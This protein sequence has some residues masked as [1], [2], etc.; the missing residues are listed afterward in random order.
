MIWAFLAAL[1][2]AVVI[3]LIWPLVRDAAKP[4]DD[5]RDMAVLK[6]Q[7]AELERDMARGVITPSEAD[8]LK[9]EIQRRV[10][11]AAR[12]PATK[13]WRE[14]AGLRSALTATLAVSV[15]MAA[16]AI[17]MS[18]GA[19]MLPAKAQKELSPEQHEMAGLV[20]QL[21]ARMANEPDNAEGWALLARSY[22]QMDRYDD[23]LEAYRHLLS[24]NPAGAEAYANYGEMLVTTAGGGVSPEAKQAFMTALTRDRDDPRSRFYVGLA[25]AQEGDARSAIAIWRD[26]TAGAPEGAPWL[27]MVRGQMFEV[28]QSA[29]VMPMNVEPRHPL[30]LNPAEMAA[31]GPPA[32]TAPSAAPPSDPS[33]IT[34]PDVSAI[35]GNFSSENLAQIQSMVGALAGRLENNPD[36]F[37]GWMMLGRS[38]TVLRNADGAKRA[39]E[40]AM[41]L[42]PGDVQPKLS[43]AS[44]LIGQTNLN[45]PAPLPADLVKISADI[46]KIEP[47]Q[48]EALFLRG[49]AAFKSGDKSAA[50]ADWAAAKKT[51]GGA[52]AAEIDRWMTAIK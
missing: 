31:A 37:N 9:L 49:L 44:V 45:S 36:D 48:P 11:S 7:M 22:R 10:L 3:G 38:Y 43:Y 32:Q 16:F 8:A 52:L 20:D 41:A 19:P 1:A 34:S 50:K 47:A 26:L 12:R 18:L 15:P 39:F 24:L 35:Q 40:K 30:D 21:A 46:L 33:D 4:D 28:A 25:Y 6:D 13:L 29:A 17:Y 23:A 5:Q 2:L 14:G 27:E 42:K 51:A